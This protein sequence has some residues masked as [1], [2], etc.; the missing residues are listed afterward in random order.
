[1]IE[2]PEY[3]MEHDLE[4]GSTNQSTGVFE[5]RIQS[6]AIVQSPP[7][8]ICYEGHGRIGDSYFNDFPIEFFC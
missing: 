8:V 2:P 3:D 1:M 5:S 4:C 7:S 6:L